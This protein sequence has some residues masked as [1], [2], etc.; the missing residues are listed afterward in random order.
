L[1]ILI[2]LGPTMPLVEARQ[3]CDAIYLPPAGQADLLSAVT[4]HRPD[5]IA[6]I[7]GVFGQS[8]SLWHK[9]ILY[10]LEQGVAVYGASSHGRTARRRDRA[11]WHD[12][13]RRSLSHERSRRD[14]RRR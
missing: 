5:V 6:L 13:F 2:F 12:R 7:D 10:A 9:E 14:R 4:L 3:L 8:L 1:K 11:L